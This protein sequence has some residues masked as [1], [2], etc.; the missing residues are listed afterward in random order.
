MTE[1]FSTTTV[2]HASN[3]FTIDGIRLP[4]FSLP[5]SERMGCSMFITVFL[6][7]KA[8]RYAAK[9][10]TLEKDAFNLAQWQD[11]L[12]LQGVNPFDATEQH[13]R[14]FLLG[15]GKRTGNVKEVKRSE[16]TLVSTNLRKLYT[17]LACYD[18]WERKRG[19]K[20]KRYGGGTLGTISEDRFTREPG[21]LS[22]TPLKYSRAQEN[23]GNKA[24]STP[25]ESEVKR[26]IAKANSDNKSENRRETWYLITSLMSRAGFRAG[27]CSTLTIASI[28]NGLVEEGEILAIPEYKNVIRRHYIPENRT[29]ILDALKKIAARGRKYLFIVIVEKTGLRE[30]PIPIKL[31]EEILDYVWTTRADF[32]KLRF[33]GRQHMAPDEVFL[34][35][36]NKAFAPESISN[37][38]GNV[39]AGCSVPGGGHK[40]RAAF[41]QSIVKDV[42]LRHRSI[43]GRAW[44]ASMVL[45]IARQMMGHKSTET[46]QPYLNDVLAEEAALE[47]EPVII[48]DTSNAADIRGISEA[49][50]EGN[51]VLKAD[52]KAIMKKHCVNPIAEPASE[53]AII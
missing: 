46:L 52:L 18:F 10:R 6:L 14:N 4:K 36:K 37:K 13:L 43:H 15:G 32:V 20:L 39:F 50:E 31:L 35:Y 3:E 41:C 26:L 42:Y 23:K 44:Q 25:S 17:I 8:M 38:L 30:A 5:M 47:G 16:L 45:E 24:H 1:S 11:Y 2:D 51:E 29:L 33:K 49:L 53:Y 48:R 9:W 21:K 40:L 34:S 28:L 19:V 27:G 7:E 12:D 22:T